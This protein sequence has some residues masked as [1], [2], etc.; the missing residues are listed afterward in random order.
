[1]D[2]IDIRPYSAADR[3]GVRSLLLETFGRASGF[4][5]FEIGNPLGEPIRVVA[6]AGGK[7][8]GFNSWNPW[9]IPTADGPKLVFQSGASAVAKSVR[10]RGIFGN[11]LRAGE[12][13]AEERKVGYFI[14][15]PNPSS[16]MS[17]LRLGWV[18]ISSMPLRVLI[19]VRLRNRPLLPDPQGCTTY[20]DIDRF[21]RWRYAK[22][23][24]LSLR[25][26]DSGKEYVTVFFRKISYGVVP[27]IKILDV[28][29]PDGTRKIGR[30]SSI[31][32]KIS[33]SPLILIRL[34]Y[35]PTMTCSRFVI[36]PRSWETPVMIKRIS[37]I[38]D[39]VG[40]SLKSALFCYGDID[41]S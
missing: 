30:I 28:L 31:A 39:D 10:G 19:R 24:A 4:D 8:V 2:R 22:N 26:Q 20:P 33:G 34:N 32:G 21:L 1:M 27:L 37:A 25:V 16:I 14:G 18:Q 3:E 9:L 12:V 15:F 13:I 29:L 5:F 6:S 35:H 40:R 36:V 23:D 41:I 17:L 7:I 11:L 38:S